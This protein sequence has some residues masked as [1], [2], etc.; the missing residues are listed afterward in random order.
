[1]E[2][3]KIFIAV[4]CPPQSIRRKF[5]GL[6]KFEN[7]KSPLHEVLKHILEI[8]S[9][10]CENYNPDVISQKADI[11]ITS[12]ATTTLC[13]FENHENLAFTREVRLQRHVDLRMWHRAPL[14]CRDIL[15]TVSACSEDIRKAD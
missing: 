13:I 15:E 1:M 3:T 6:Q 10:M 7:G 2:A 9:E 12:S 4:I 8:S 14:S 11:L 5:H